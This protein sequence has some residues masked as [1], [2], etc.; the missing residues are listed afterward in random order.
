MN[1]YN[2]RAMICD[3]QSFMTLENHPL[4]TTLNLKGSNDKFT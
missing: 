4:S 3:P 2:F 1:G